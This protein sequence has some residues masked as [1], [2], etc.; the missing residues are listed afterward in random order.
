VKRIIAALFGL[1][2]AHAAHATTCP[3]PLQIKDANGNIYSFDTIVDQSGNCA[4]QSSGFD[5]GPVT[6]QQ[7]PSSSSH[8]AGTSVGGLFTLA[9]GRT[10]PGS[11]AI[12]TVSVVSAGGFTG[13]Y[14]VRMWKT[15][16]SINTTCTDNSP[17]VSN[18]TDDLNLIVPPFALTLSQP[19]QTTGDTKTYNSL[20]G[21]WFDYT[22][23]SGNIFVCLVATATDTNDESHLVTVVLSG[24]QD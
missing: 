23:A 1:V 6:A 11:G 13:G 19:V 7:T 17:F 4:F 24:P 9:L 12:T 2:L 14:L 21:V 10:I 16:P 5:S 3:S 20:Q 8:A 15:Q 18:A 22:T